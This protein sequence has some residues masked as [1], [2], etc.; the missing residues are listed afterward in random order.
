MLRLW[1]RRLSHRTE[2]EPEDGSGFCPGSSTPYGVESGSLATSQTGAAGKEGL[3]VL[4]SR[5]G[6]LEAADTSGLVRAWAAPSISEEE[7]RLS[8]PIV[9][10]DLRR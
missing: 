9:V 8:E 1:R 3:Q 4:R 6:I 7:G 5:L 10:E 2:I